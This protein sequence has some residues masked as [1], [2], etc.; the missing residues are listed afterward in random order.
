MKNKLQALYAVLVVLLLLLSIGIAFAGQVYDRAVV[1]LGVTGAARWTNTASYA[2]YSSL[3]L[4]R[5]TIYKNSATT[6]DLTITRISADTVYTQAVVTATYP[7]PGTHT[8]LAFNYLKYGDMLAI[9]S[10]TATNGVVMLE[11][12]VQRH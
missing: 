3:D 8:S 7:T 6:N 9:S 2:E 11:F 4:K 10:A 12:E 5:I 1:T